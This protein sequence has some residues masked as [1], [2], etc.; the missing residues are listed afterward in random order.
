MIDRQID[1]Y[2]K[3]RD[4]LGRKYDGKFIVISEDLSI[5]Q[6]PSVEEAYRFGE[7]TWGVGN[8]IIQECHKEPRVVT[9]P[10]YLKVVLG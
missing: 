10:Q 8:F 2:W 7:K 3:N 9:V 1:F 5:D 6:F 4:E